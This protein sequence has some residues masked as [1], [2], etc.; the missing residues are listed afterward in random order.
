[1][2]HALNSTASAHVA[3]VPG[4]GSH[5]GRVRLLRVCN[6]RLPFQV[7]FVARR[8]QHLLAGERRRGVLAQGESV[9]VE[10]YRTVHYEGA[11]L[12][13]ARVGYELH[14]ILH[15]VPPI[16]DVGEACTAPALGAV[17]AYAVFCEPACDW[18]VALAAER[19]QMSTQHLKAQL[20]RE[21][22]ALTA[23]LREQRLMRALLA[24]LAQPH[25]RQNLPAL[26]GQFGFGSAA[27]LDDAFDER[28]GSTASQ[29]ATLAWYPALTWSFAAS[30]AEQGRAATAEA[31][32]T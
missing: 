31:A 12:I 26:A 22:N 18:S 23:I 7:E 17:L 24:L 32:A 5:P 28:F 29:I 14:L 6:I 13:D 9:V 10:R 11:T 4:R 8:G 3:R 1:M 16:I 27:R 30:A 19:M 25:A 15:D 20:F 2:M 21:N